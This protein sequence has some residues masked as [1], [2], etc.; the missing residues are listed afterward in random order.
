MVYVDGFVLPVALKNLDAY[1]RL[2]RTAEK[3][4]RKHGALDY[5]ECVG[6]D[7][8][9]KWAVSFRKLLKLKRGETAMFSYIIYKSRAHRDR[10]NKKVMKD[11]E[12]LCKPGAPMPFDL[13]RMACGGF[14]SVVGGSK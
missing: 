10:I 13:K 9:L 5:V 4:W 1:I 3:V 7:L 11:L 8:D 14:R 12:P 6:Q 2:A